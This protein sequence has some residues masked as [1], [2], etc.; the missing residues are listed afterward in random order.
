[1]DTE[2]DKRV[3]KFIFTE[4]LNHA[5]FEND[6]H[7]GYVEF[8]RELVPHNRDRFRQTSEPKVLGGGRFIVDREKKQIILYG[9]SD[10]YGKCNK[11]QLEK[12]LEKNGA[13]SLF[14]LERIEWMRHY[15]EFERDDERRDSDNDY[16]NFSDFN[17]VVQDSEFL[18]I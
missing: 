9:S 18:T 7:F 5:K 2:K 10:D 15:R 14:D 8:H 11:K 6:I 13:N 3:A 1:M 12:Y 17:F 16:W 4:Q